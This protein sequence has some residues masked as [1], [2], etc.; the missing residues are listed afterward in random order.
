MLLAIKFYLG[1]NKINICF[2]CEF[3]LDN[4]YYDN[5][6]KEMQSFFDENGFKCDGENFVSQQ[7]SVAIK[8]NDDKQTYNLLVADITEDGVGEFSNINTWLFDDS[9]TA[10]DATSVGVDFTN[11]LREQLGIKHERKLTENGIDLPS[12]SKTGNMTISGFTKKML[13]V[14][15]A[16]KDEYKAHISENGTFLYL[17]FYGVSLVPRLVRLFEEGT[18]KQIKKFYDIIEDSYVKG[19]RETINITVALLSAAAYKNEK[20]H[21]KIMDMLADNKHFLSAYNAFSNTFAKNNKLISV[22]VKK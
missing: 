18:K 21:A 8:Y 14:F 11:S 10:K 7:K 20:V 22:L 17:N 12:A 1:Y 9:Q 2:G 15:P 4:R 19:D 16:M 5:V 3:K 6:I 13:D